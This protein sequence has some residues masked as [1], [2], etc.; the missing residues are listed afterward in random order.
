[1]KYFI[2]KSDGVI[3]I[4]TYLQN[5]YRSKG[6]KTIRIPVLVDKLH[7]D[8]YQ[9][10]IA[11]F[12]KEKLNFIYAG[13]PGKKDIV[14]NVI[15]AVEKLYK[16]GMKIQFHILGPTMSQLKLI[17]KR[18]ISDA[19]LCYGRV[20]Q[21]MVP[22]YLKQANFS[23]L[24]R[25]NERFAHAGFSTKFVESLSAGLPVIANYTSD[26]ELYL[27]DGFNG[28][29]VK[30]YSVDSIMEAIKRISNIDM[31]SQQIM[32]KNSQLTAFENF[33]YRMYSNKISLFLRQIIE[34]K[35]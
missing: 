23:V 35:E 27:K 31:N 30:D 19:I 29:V 3:A 20:S 13:V 25:P 33:D 6:L 1:V 4:R 10:T 17:M 16:E 26:I 18:P 14:V 34:N 24:I 5:Y 12:D 32:R 21:N 8:K 22:A 2:P 15:D 7:S 28:I 11:Q 9:K